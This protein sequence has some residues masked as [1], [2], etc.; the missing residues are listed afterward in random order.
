MV[1]GL[2]HQRAL[3]SRA[4]PTEY[5]GRDA[6]DTESSLSGGGDQLFRSLVE[7]SLGL[8]CVHDLSGNLLFVNAAAAATLGFRPEDGIGWNLRR[9]LAPT[10]ENE[11]DAYLERIR[12]HGVDSGLMRL[13]SKEGAERV[14]LYRN[15]LFEEAGM[16]A[17]V[18][19]HAQDVTDR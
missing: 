7:H 15:V 14:W 10:V 19:G 1:K 16:P 2:F 12:T 8:M 11:F 17:R 18:L 3:S 5:R 6:M 13:V 4:T 9:F